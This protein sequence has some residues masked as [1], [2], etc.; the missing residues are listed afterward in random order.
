MLRREE[1]NNNTKNKASR[2]RT[3]IRNYT[4][5]LDEDCITPQPKQGKNKKIQDEDVNHFSP[6]KYRTGCLY[7][8][9]KLVNI[10][11]CL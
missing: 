7:L 8:L 4:R 10:F 9:C 2:M 5:T 3:Q 1:N 6:D 11:T